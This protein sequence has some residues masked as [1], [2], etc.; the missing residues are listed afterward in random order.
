[1]LLVGGIALV[2]LV[3]ADTA[4]LAASKRRVAGS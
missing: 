1:M 3:I 4:F 2:V